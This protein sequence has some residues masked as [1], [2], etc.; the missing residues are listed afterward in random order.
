MGRRTLRQAGLRVCADELPVQFSVRTS[1][2][3]LAF[4][5]MS[6]VTVSATCRLL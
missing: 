4:A 6:H 5:S 3:I 2:Y 1:Q